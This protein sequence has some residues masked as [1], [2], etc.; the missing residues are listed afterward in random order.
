MA[1]SDPKFH[2]PAYWRS[3]AEELRAKATKLKYPG[4]K[5]I[6]LKIADS[7]DK[8]ALQAEQRAKRGG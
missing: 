4:S 6:W 1:E 7:F 3:R 8:L 5:Q 2:T